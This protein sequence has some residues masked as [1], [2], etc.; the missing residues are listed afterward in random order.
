[1][2]IHL[3]SLKNSLSVCARF[4]GSDENGE[5]VDALFGDDGT[6]CING[7]GGT[8]STDYRGIAYIGSVRQCE[9]EDE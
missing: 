9:D 6:I 1:M 3:E 2:L 7:V 5:A 8:Q 4:V